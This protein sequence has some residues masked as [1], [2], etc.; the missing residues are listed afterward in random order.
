M[1]ERTMHVDTPLG[2]STQRALD[3]VRN[4]HAA[5]QIATREA[6]AELTEALYAA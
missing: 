4:L 6:V 5:G 3:A 1:S 2:P